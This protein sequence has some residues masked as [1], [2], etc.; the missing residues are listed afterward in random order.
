MPCSME[1]AT[2]YAGVMRSHKISVRAMGFL[3]L[4]VLS[5]QVGCESAATLQRFEATHQQMGTQ[6]RLVFYCESESLAKH[7]TGE[8]F[9]RIDELNAILSDYDPKSELNALSASSG[10]GESMTVSRDLWNVLVHAQTTSLASA[11]SF[12]VTVGPLVKLW[13][14]ARRIRMMP[15]EEPLADALAAVGYE[16]I[17]LDDE[18]KTATLTTPNMKLDLGGIAKGYAVDE[19]MR[20]LRDHGITRMLVDGGGDIGL[21]DSPPDKEGWRIGL[22][23][24]EGRDS[25][26]SRFITLTNAAIATSGDAWQFV[27]IDGRRY[28]HLVNPHTGL[29]LTDHSMVTVVA[30]DCATADALASA[31]SVLGPA[32]GI[33]LVEETEGG[34]AIIVRKP[35]EQVEV[36]ESKRVKELSL[37]SAKKFNR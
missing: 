2:C 7:V 10:S 36:H 28:S 17:V 30:P 16:K 13:R 20:I 35:G 33:K 27:V 29:G 14:R 25:P 4:A 26:P 31:V 8:T 18:D 37:E 32:E 1:G 15:K 9:Q 21:G 6:F 22:V 24:L 23:P 12:D 3:V 11:G 34:A 5:L 19:A